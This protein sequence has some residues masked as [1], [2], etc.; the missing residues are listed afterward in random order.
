VSKPFDATAKDLLET[1]PG[2]W[3]EYLHLRSQGPV[4]VINAD[5]STVTTEADKVLRVDDEPQPWLVHIELQASRD[6]RFIPRL[7]RYNVLAHGGFLV[8]WVVLISG[9]GRLQSA[10]TGISVRI[11]AD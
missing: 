6:R 10:Q 8:D 7:L 11:W 1:H 4:R 2:S 5:L 9:W 3:M